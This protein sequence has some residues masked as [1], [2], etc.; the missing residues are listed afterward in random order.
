MMIYLLTIIVTRIYFVWFHLNVKSVLD[1]LLLIYVTFIIWF[2]CDKKHSSANRTLI[3]F[4][5]V[6]PNIKQW[7]LASDIPAILKQRIWYFYTGHILGNGIRQ[8]RTGHANRN[9]MVSIRIKSFYIKYIFLDFVYWSPC[10]LLVAL[11]ELTTGQ[12]AQKA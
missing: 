10:F 12:T 1:H 2:S 8:V 4:C 3:H 11:Y 9:I 5:V 7:H 6:F